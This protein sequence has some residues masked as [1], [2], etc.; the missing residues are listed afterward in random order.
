[1]VLVLQGGAVQQQVLTLAEPVLQEVL[2]RTT[3]T[4]N[5]LCA[6]LTADDI[7]AKARTQADALTREVAELVAGR[8]ETIQRGGGAGCIPLWIERNAAAV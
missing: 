6:M 4:L 5:Q 8:D 1:M 3:Q 2:T 7:R